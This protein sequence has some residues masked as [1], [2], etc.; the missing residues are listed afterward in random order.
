MVLYVQRQLYT[1][2]CQTTDTS[3]LDT[4]SPGNSEGVPTDIVTGIMFSINIP[5]TSV[6]GSGTG[7]II[8]AICC[9]MWLWPTTRSNSKDYEYIFGNSK[10]LRRWTS[11]PLLRFSGLSFRI[12]AATTTSAAG[13][14]DHLIQTLIL[15]RWS[16]DCY[17]RYI[18]Q[19]QPCGWRRSSPRT[20]GS[21]YLRTCV[22]FAQSF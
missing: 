17:I 22:C 12:G 7:S 20:E 15:G 19:W 8:M 10:S 18:S 3:L 9:S 5:G 6:Q 14:L 1:A 2:N 16:S 4:A 21:G 13:V 11:T